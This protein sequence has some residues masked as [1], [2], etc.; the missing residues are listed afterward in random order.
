MRLKDRVAL[1]TGAGRGIGEAIAR[2]FAAEGAIV[3]ATDVVEENIKKLADELNAQGLKSMAIPVNVTDKNDVD[4]MVQKV[5]S[6][7]GRLDILINNAA[8]NR[9]ALTKKMTEEQWD[10]VI[11]VNLKGSFL[12]AKAAAE[13]MME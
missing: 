1:I 5:V 2:R 9:D 4:A 10:A 6:N 11:N 13:P 8:I 3:V 12:C 7:Y